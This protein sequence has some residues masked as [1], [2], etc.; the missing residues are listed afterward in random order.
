MEAVKLRFDSDNVD[1]LIAARALKAPF[2]SF[3]LILDTN[4]GW[5]IRVG[6]TE[7]KLSMLQGHQTRLSYP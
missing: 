7:N 2:H 6:G 1:D 4:Q 3:K 5:S